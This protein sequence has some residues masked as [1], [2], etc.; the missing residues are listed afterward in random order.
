MFTYFLGTHRP[1]W[2]N[3]LDVP[4]FVSRTTIPKTKLPRARTRW[5][6]DSGGYTQITKYGKWTISEEQYVDEVRRFQDEIGNL[7]WAGPMDWMVEPEA[8]RK[9]GFTTND[10]QMAT[11]ANFVKLRHMAPDLPII[12][13]LQGWK[14]DQYRTHV[15]MY[16]EIWGVDLYREPLVGI[17]SVCRREGTAAFAPISDMMYEFWKDGMRMHAFGLSKPA[18]VKLCGS[19]VSSDSLAWSRSGRDLSNRVGQPKNLQNSPGYALAWRKK[20]LRDLEEKGGRQRT[21][22][23]V[24]WH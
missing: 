18:M 13:V 16:R 3:E 6:L 7:E 14:S 20:L 11:C 12:P 5:C 9:S 1:T 21:G 15:A 17:G 24:A 10:H 22:C 2:L 19:L 23:D 4:M 8:R